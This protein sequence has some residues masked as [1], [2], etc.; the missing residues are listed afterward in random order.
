M[1]DFEKTSHL[2]NFVA[3][4]QTRINHEPNTKFAGKKIILQ[5]ISIL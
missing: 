2:V 1:G 3:S 5:I 4:K